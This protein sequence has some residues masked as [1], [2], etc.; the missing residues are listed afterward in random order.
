MYRRDF[1]RG[2]SSWQD[3]CFEQ[4]D[5]VRPVKEAHDAWAPCLMHPCGQASVWASACG[6]DGSQEV[7]VCFGK[8]RLAK[9]IPTVRHGASGSSTILNYAQFEV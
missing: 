4:T 3:L 1:L 5:N 7:D 6:R 8:M 9:M 2:Q